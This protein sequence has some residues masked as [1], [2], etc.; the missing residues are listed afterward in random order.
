MKKLIIGLFVVILM[1]TAVSTLE[2]FTGIDLYAAY[3]IGVMWYVI[4]SC[5]KESKKRNVKAK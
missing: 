1:G 3:E 4:Y 5:A 2:R